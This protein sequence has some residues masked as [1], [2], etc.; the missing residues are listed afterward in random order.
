M[1]ERH[2]GDCVLQGEECLPKSRWNRVEYK[3][4]TSLA[5]M[6]V[7]Q[8]RWR[9]RRRRDSRWRKVTLTYVMLGTDWKSYGCN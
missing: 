1:K 9:G 5:P 2:L 3:A 8:E 6:G 4:K 7:S